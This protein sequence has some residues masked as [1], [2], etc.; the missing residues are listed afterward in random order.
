[1]LRNSKRIHNNQTSKRI[2]AVGG[3]L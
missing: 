3:R 1:L 2:R